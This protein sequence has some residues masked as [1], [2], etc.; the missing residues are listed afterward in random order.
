MNGTP[1]NKLIADAYE[2]E[3]A[4][5]AAGV[6][7]QDIT[8]L[9]RLINAYKKALKNNRALRTENRQLRKRLESL[10]IQDLSAG[11]EERE[12]RKLAGEPRPTTDQQRSDP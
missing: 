12:A 10:G 4:L 2:A 9:I 7:A 3:H 1:P 8:T 5:L 11:W 6:D